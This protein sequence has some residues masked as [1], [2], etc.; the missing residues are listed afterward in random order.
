MYDDG[1]MRAGLPR[2]MWG[3][4]FYLGRDDIRFVWQNCSVDRPCYQ[5][6]TNVPPLKKTQ[7]P[8]DFRIASIP[9]FD[10]PDLASAIRS[11]H[12]STWIWIFFLTFGGSWPLTKTCFRS[13]LDV[14]LGWTLQMTN[15]PSEYRQYRSYSYGEIRQFVLDAQR[16][17]SSLPCGQASKKLWNPKDLWWSDG[18]GGH[19]QCK[20]MQSVGF[21]GSNLLS[22][23]GLRPGRQ[24]LRQQTVG[25]TRQLPCCYAM[26]A[27]VAALG[28][29]FSAVGLSALAMV[30]GLDSWV[31][32]SCFGWL[33]CQAKRHDG[34]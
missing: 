3:G 22:G 14:E 10:K 9:K 26:V 30:E 6:S 4:N 13:S 24:N 8:H 11:S 34:M 12:D 21:A 19:Q 5:D 20:L 15:A 16:L 7:H 31:R 28:I 17:A 27:K 18:H 29:T 33:L 25:Q 1:I 32:R 23:V 2:V